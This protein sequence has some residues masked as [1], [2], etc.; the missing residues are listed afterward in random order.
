[1]EESDKLFD[2]RIANAT[3]AAQ[4]IARVEKNE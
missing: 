3:N 4:S 2:H 1:M